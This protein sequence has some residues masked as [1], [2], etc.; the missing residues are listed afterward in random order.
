VV[1]GDAARRLQVTVADARRHVRATDTAYDLVVADNFHPARSG[2]AALYTVE[3]F[4][5]VR[6]R[7]APGGLFC[8]WLPLHQMDLAT[9]RS[10]VASFVTAYPGAWA[11]LATNSLETP[12]VALVAH[13]DGRP[14]DPAQWRQRLAT[15]T[16]PRPPAAFGLGDEWA[17]AG[18]AAGA[19]VNTDDHPVVAYLAPRITYAPDS[20]PR[21]RLMALLQEMQVTPT[22]VAGPQADAAW[23]ARM[24]AYWA[25]RNQFL[26]AGQRVKPAGDARHMLAQVREPLLGVLHT[27]ADF[28]PAYE[29]L[30]R[31]ATAVAPTDP[32][33][34]RALL[35]ELARLQP[36]W[37]EA[38]E[39]LRGLEQPAAAQ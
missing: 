15:L 27:S 34:A 35:A 25:A 38:A 13:A 20:L 19:A 28:R 37:P 29:P 6:Q 24:A 17:L 36:R 5:A 1:G 33:A 2:S 32:A 22:D 31:L 26:E 18:F 12:V 21:D 7:L 23:S 8:Q 10:I 30:L 4:Q 11:M 9:L 16:L 3:H 14:F 39:Q